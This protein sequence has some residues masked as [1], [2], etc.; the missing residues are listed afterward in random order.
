MAVTEV[1][2]TAAEVGM[3]VMEDGAAV[4]TGVDGITAAATGA[5]ASGSHSLSEV[6]SSVVLLRHSADRTSGA[7]STIK[8]SGFA[9]L[10]C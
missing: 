4:G 10:N 2:G 7:T 8:G 9:E 1:A 6:R 3:E 5:M